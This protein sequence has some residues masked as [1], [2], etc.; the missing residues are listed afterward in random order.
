MYLMCLGNSIPLKT[1]MEKSTGLDTI[2]V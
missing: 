1:Q 2:N